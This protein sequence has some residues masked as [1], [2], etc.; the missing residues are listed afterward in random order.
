M[1]NDAPLVTTVS[2]K[3]GRPPEIDLLRA[4]VIAVIDQNRTECQVRFLSANG[5]PIGAVRHDFDPW[6][7]DGLVINMHDMLRKAARKALNWDDSPSIH[8]QL[9]R[10]QSAA[11]AASMGRK[12]VNG[13]VR[14]FRVDTNG[15]MVRVLAHPA[16]I[17]GC[18]RRSMAAIRAS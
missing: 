2:A 15:F 18:R 10:P 7:A 6:N 17:F 16:D 12:T 5:P 11:V 1:G 4:M 3:G 8:H 9:G 14:Q 13:H